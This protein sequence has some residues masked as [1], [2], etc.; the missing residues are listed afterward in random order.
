MSSDKSQSCL[1]MLDVA[2]RIADSEE[3]MFR[4]NS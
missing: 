4:H 1:V 2:G 3:T